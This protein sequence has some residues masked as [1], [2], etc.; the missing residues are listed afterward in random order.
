M[1]K[2][3]VSLMVL[4]LCVPAMAAT[5][6]IDDGTPGDGIGTITVTREGTEN[7]VGLAL[8]IAQTAGGNIAGVTVDTATFDIFPDAAYDLGVAYTYG[9]G[10]PIANPLA[11]G[12][13]GI[14][15][16]IAISVGALNGAA[17][18]GATGSASVVITVTVDTADTTIEVQENALRG[19]IV[20]T[21]GTGEDISSG[22]AGVVSGTITVSSSCWTGDAASTLEFD[23]VAAAG[24]LN[25]CWCISNNPRQCHGDAEG[26]AEGKSFYW[27]STL[28]LGVL[29]G[30]WN[31]DIATLVAG[32]PA[33]ICA[34]FDH[35]PE[36]K[37]LYRVST[38]D[39][40]I[41][42]ANW[43]LA[44]LPAPDCADALGIQ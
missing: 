33:D 41:L 19:G 20:L 40:G 23:A 34:D 31:E 17:T 13:V 22:V 42:L 39:L 16:S 44:N 30:A 21:D 9:A 8:E 26:T 43:N 11:A 1:K 36:G 29:L 10:T 37:S 24:A 25:D 35:Q 38:I 28:D 12:E 7:I 6:V 3:L 18:A 14:S 2:I 27:V 4:A 5:V 15:N 32:G